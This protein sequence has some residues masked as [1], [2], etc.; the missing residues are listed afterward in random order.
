MKVMKWLTWGILML[1]SVLGSAQADTISNE[2]NRGNLSDRQLQTVYELAV[3]YPVGGEIAIAYLDGDSTIYYGA[4]RLPG[5]VVTVENKSSA[6]GIG[7]I[8]KVFTATLL[9]DAVVNGEL[10]LD[11]SVD[12]AYDFAFANEVAFTYRELA[13]HTAGLPRLPSNMPGA[14]NFN[15]PYESYT[16]DSLQAYLRDHVEA[17]DKSQSAYSNLGFGIL[18]HALSHRLW[19]TS[20]AEALEAKI[21]A[22]FEMH[23]TTLGGGDRGDIVVGR[24]VQTGEP[25]GRWEFTDA[26]AGAGAIL[27]TPEDMVR[28]LR[29][30]L[31]TTQSTLALTRQPVFE[32]N[33]RQAVGLGWQI[34]TPE[35]GRTVYWHNGGT[36]SYRSF[37]GLDVAERR[38]V[39]VLTNA[40]LMGQEVD[41]AGMGFL[42]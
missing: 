11:D 16:T 25:L 37:V 40:L 30:Q 20:L 17:G 7:S 29:A 39:V 5:K 24:N 21:F 23:A 3:K 41:G 28:F 10:Q 19:N 32:T 9:A 4:R 1:R 27:S 6:F 2:L 26:M 31:D 22:P 33:A 36:G 8:T 15:N 13:S 35:P 14:L 18:G 42:R 38:G 12:A 34:V